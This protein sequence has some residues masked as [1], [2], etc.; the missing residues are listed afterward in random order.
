[1][2]IEKIESKPIRVL[3]SLEV[4]NSGIII[5][6]TDPRS[7]PILNLSHILFYQTRSKEVSLL[8]LKVCILINLF[9][10]ANL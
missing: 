7:H 9:L 10:M 1:M 6:N 3:C 5:I 8:K 2:T 4:Q